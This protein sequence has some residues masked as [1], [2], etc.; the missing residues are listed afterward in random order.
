MS[1]F[2]TLLIL[3]III[4]AVLAVII[5]VIETIFDSPRHFVASGMHVVSEE[6]RR[7]N[8]HHYTLIDDVHIEHNGELIQIDHILVSAFG[9]FIIETNPHT[10]DIHGK[11]ESKKWTQV[12]GY[13]DRYKMSN[14]I[15][16]VQERERILHKILGDKLKGEIVP[17]VAFP[18]AKILHVNERDMIG[19]TWEIIEKIRSFEHEI[20]NHAERMEIVH[21][22]KAANV[23]DPAILAKYQP[24]L[25]VPA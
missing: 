16:N 9:V 7:F 11:P 1:I 4:L 8:K 5:F 12:I 23:V 10:G 18:F 15:K 2:L 25:K 17:F 3:I 24:E 22:V 13:H 6:L 21:A 19:K 20:Y 14:P